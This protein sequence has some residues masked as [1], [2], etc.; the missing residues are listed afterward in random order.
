MANS[1]HFSF[2]LLGLHQKRF[3]LHTPAS[4]IQHINRFVQRILVHFAKNPHRPP[5]RIFQSRLCGPHL[6]HPCNRQF[7]RHPPYR[8][9]RGPDLV[10]DLH[11]LTTYTS[12]RCAPTPTSALFCMA[13]LRQLPRCL[14]PS[15][16]VSLHPSS[17]RPLPYPSPR[18]EYVYEQCFPPSLVRFTMFISLQPIVRLPVI[19][20]CKVWSG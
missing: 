5:G 18:I 16:A 3:D 17:S 9:V 1:R 8:T 11:P 2:S 20:W 14:F 4:R 12:F 10:Y 7:C 6:D 13:L 19:Y 15:L